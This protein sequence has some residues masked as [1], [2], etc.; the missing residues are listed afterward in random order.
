MFKF[1]RHEAHK[2]ASDTQ[3]AFTAVDDAMRMQAR[4]T[5]SFLDTTAASGMTERE[6]QRVLESVHGSQKHAIDC[7]SDLVAATIMMTS[8]LQKSNQAETD[9]GCGGSGPW[10]VVLGESASSET[11]SSAA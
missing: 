5:I 10:S 9:F 7:R 4:I 1:D 11:A 2:L 8:Y 6:R 3:A